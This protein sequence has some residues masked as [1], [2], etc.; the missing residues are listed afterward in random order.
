[1]ERHTNENTIELK[2]IRASDLPSR[3]M[4]TLKVYV[5]VLP[6]GEQLYR[7]ETVAGPE[8]RWDKTFVIR[9]S[10]PSSRIKLQVHHSADSLNSKFIGEAEILVDDL[11]RGESG[12]VRYKL[13]KPGP[14]LRQK[15]GKI[16]VSAKVHVDAKEDAPA[17]VQSENVSEAPTNSSGLADPP[18]HA[19]SDVMAN[20]PTPMASPITSS[21]LHAPPNSSPP[22]IS[23][24]SVDLENTESSL[25][26]M[27]T[28]RFF[29]NA[30]AIP[31]NSGDAIDAVGDIISEILQ[32]VLH[33]GD[34]LADV[35]PYARVTWT[36]L[37][38]GYKVQSTP[39]Y[40]FT[41]LTKWVQIL[42]AQVD[43]DN[44]I[45]ALW[46]TARDVVALLDRKNSEDLQG[47]YLNRIITNVIKQIYECCQFL[48]KYGEQGF[49]GRTLHATLAPNLDSHIQEFFDAFTD[50]K[51]KFTRGLSMESWTG[52]R[53]IGNEL[54]AMNDMLQNI[55][56]STLVQSGVPMAECDTHRQCLPGTRTKL[57]ENIV[58]WIHDP[59]RGRLLWLSGAMGTGKS[60]V[61]NTI[62]GLLKD[63]K[64]L[65]ASCRFEKQVDPSIVFRYLAYQ[66]ARIDK[67]VKDNLV[68]VL[69]TNGDIASASLLDQ[70]LKV[71]VQPLQATDLVG[72]V[73]LVFDALDE[74][75]QR[76][77][78]IQ[79]DILSFFADDKFD[80][81]DWIKIIITS[82]DEVSIRSQL[83]IAKG[84][85]LL[86]ID[87]YG[88][89]GN[90]I[91]FFVQHH[92][93]DIAERKMLTPDWPP[94]G[95]ARALAD[96]AGGQFQWASI[97]CQF[98]AGNP[99]SRLSLILSTQ[100]TTHDGIHTLDHLYD[101]VLQDAYAA[102]NKHP[103][104][105]LEFGY[106]VGT[107]AVATT[108]FHPVD[109][110]ELLDLRTDQYNSISLPGKDAFS[111]EGVE[112][113]V[114][115]SEDRHYEWLAPEMHVFI[116]DMLPTWVNTMSRLG[117]EW[118]DILIKLMDWYTVPQ[119]YA[120][121]VETDLTKKLVLM[122]SI[123][124]DR[125]PLEH[126]QDEEDEEGIAFLADGITES[127]PDPALLRVG[128]G[129]ISPTTSPWDSSD[130]PKPGAWF[131]EDDKEIPK[132]E[133]KEYEA[134]RQHIEDTIF[135][136]LTDALPPRRMTTF[137]DA[138]RLL[139]DI[140]IYVKDVE[141]YRKECMLLSQRSSQVLLATHEAVSQ[142]AGDSRSVKQT[143]Q[144]I[145]DC[146]EG[147]RTFFK[148]LSSLRIWQ[149]TFSREQIERKL[150]HCNEDLAN[151]INLFMLSASV[152]LNTRQRLERG[153]IPSDPE[154]L[155]SYLSM[156]NSTVD[157]SER[158]VWAVLNT[159]VDS[160]EQIAYG[161]SSVVFKGTHKD[162]VVS[163]KLLTDK[164][165]PKEAV[166]ATVNLW[167]SLRHD[168]IVSFIG[169]SD[170]Q[171]ATPPWFFVMPYCE[172]GDL[173]T[174]VKNKPVIDHEELLDMA[175][176]IAGGMQ[177]LHS[178]DIVHRNLQGANVLV[179]AE[180][181]CKITGFTYS[182]L[183]NADS[184]KPQSLPLPPETLQWQAPEVLRDPSAV[185]PDVDIYSYAMTFVELFTGGNNP[186]SGQSAAAVRDLVLGAYLPSVPQRDARRL[187]ADSHL[188]STVRKRRPA[189][190]SVSPVENEVRDII[191]ACWSEE[192]AVRPGFP[193][194]WE[195]VRSAGNNLRFKEIVGQVGGPYY[196]SD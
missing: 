23:G 71:V 82:R 169:A 195:E 115:E 176:D 60:S 181:T 196:D 163:I 36:V 50:F 44:R 84:V 13:A 143:A 179:A 160:G 57:I 183:M 153:E 166:L 145:I 133:R 111:M 189:L 188:L 172:H 167:R 77:L 91:Y 131:V 192:P 135:K 40:N 152:G 178:Q 14:K 127:L 123:I 34:S 184:H 7:T 89:T 187:I 78:R 149:A 45:R 65:G 158:P 132:R 38:G 88:G 182:V 54:A 11:L 49:L 25:D 79:D 155:E 157:T 41:P 137:V 27:S 140:W 126:A 47:E 142:I 190:P 119:E 69:Q 48:R 58:E 120:L 75:S 30:P 37:S 175:R 141:H 92:L 138:A 63:L 35:H 129:S 134:S 12:E 117:L 86:S 116:S 168:Y 159:E 125:T 144:R 9:V 19:T 109:L 98:I 22:V 26:A 185:S 8:P 95:A 32:T 170:P 33:L 113:H 97:T 105:I 121:L 55:W 16:F 193:Q 94:E 61:A 150:R 99:R 139:S 177:Y 70:A 122:T 110:N 31:S 29:Q 68:S 154:S 10:G 96:R 73:V 108:S 148:S 124:G 42:K 93:Q 67:S 66:L 151:I 28:P 6:G 147:I 173:V 85:E 103:S 24:L 118:R 156:L 90:D 102:R 62:V 130:I 107:V 51:E 15:R 2:V 72:P 165:M 174:Y 53:A 164:A 1:M 4:S 76:D 114:S 162:T 112:Q 18:L 56:L 136:V 171:A 161:A 3:W 194:V 52:V 104:F 5:L 180:D 191:A 83:E 39:V 101:S 186:W 87:D 20:L 128:D 17:V 74:I 21:P 106:V 46:E 59:S 64:R 81:P 100:L 43:R 80:L 146:F